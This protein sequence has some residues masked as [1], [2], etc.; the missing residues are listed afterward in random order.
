MDTEGPV[1][2]ASESTER[3]EERKVDLVEWELA[4]YVWKWVL[5]K[6]L[7]GLATGRMKSVTIWP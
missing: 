6:R 5:C 7:S 3:E 4:Q 2:V 1:D